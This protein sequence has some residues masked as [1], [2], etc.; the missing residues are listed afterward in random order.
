MGLKKNTS[1]ARAKKASRNGIKRK[2]RKLE[3]RR[4][5]RYF[6]MRRQ[7]E[8][9]S[10]AD[11]PT[12]GA[13]VLSRA[14]PSPTL[15]S[16]EQ[17]AM[18]A[19]VELRRRRIFAEQKQDP[20]PRP[21]K[22]QN[23]W[24]RRGV[25]SR[26]GAGTFTE[27][28]AEKLLDA[29]E[30][31]WFDKLERDERNMNAN[32]IVKLVIEGKANRRI[33]RQVAERK[34]EIHPLYQVIETSLSGLSQMAPAVTKPVGPRIVQ[35]AFAER[36]IRELVLFRGNISIARARAIFVFLSACMD[37]GVET[38]ADIVKA[39]QITALSGAY[40][41]GKSRF[42][43]KVSDLAHLSGLHS[44]LTN[45]GVY[46]FL[47]RIRQ[48]TSVWPLTPG[49]NRWADHVRGQL[50]IELEPVSRYAKWKTKRPWRIRERPEH[51]EFYPYI[52]GPPTDEMALV[53]RVHEAV[54]RYL[55][56][57][58]RADVCQE[59]LVDILAG[60]MLVEQLG[61][62]DFGR[63]IRDK[64]K[65]VRGRFTLSLDEPFKSHKEKSHGDRLPTR[66]DVLPSDIKHW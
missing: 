31:L 22:G 19:D 13:T 14:I 37:A 56:N 41:N 7:D 43:S 10:P 61:G 25:S 15:P 18:R 66:G 1:W 5:T 60:N 12:A 34:V 47:A 59:L 55:P 27:G 17:M 49:I 57:E 42:I 2:H 35:A 33:R 4:V 30:P 45:L 64:M 38:V 50:R 16:A 58:L 9:L 44:P 3:P 65:Q 11:V 62:E 26:N 36:D 28:I 8:L 32:A 20:S 63:L 48:T 6:E 51:A 46:G 53:L 40:A 24:A 23:V 29:V 52:V 54:P 21:A 39:S